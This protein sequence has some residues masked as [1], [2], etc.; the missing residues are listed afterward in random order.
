LTRIL[1][2]SS[3]PR[4]KGYAVGKDNFITV[5]DKELDA[6]KIE[7]TRTIDIDSFVPRKEID[8][9][10]FDAPEDKV[11][12]EAFAVIRDAMRNKEVVGIGRVVLARRERPIM[13]EPYR[14][15][16]RTM[17]LRDVSEVRDAAVYFEDIPDIKIP[18]EMKELAEVI[19][20]R[21]TGHLDP[22]K[23][24]DRYENAVVDLLKAKEAGLP[25]PA[26]EPEPRPHNIIDIMDA[27][28]R[29]IEAEKAAPSRAAEA[30]PR[31]PSKARSGV[32]SKAPIKRLSPRKG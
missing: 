21:K 25:T 3:I 30:K 8:A 28:R 2:T 9:G 31:A 15:G 11:S 23:F 26:Q 10:Y 5:E 29:S 17:T 14:K 13:L 7:S 32:K 12:Q 1:R 6:I 27:L 20:D 22:A 16:I 18:A 4:T 19:I 24:E